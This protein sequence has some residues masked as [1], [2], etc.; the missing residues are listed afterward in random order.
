MSLDWSII[1]NIVLGLGIIIQG[2]GKIISDTKIKE[3]K[4][5]IIKTKEAQIT[6]FKELLVAEKEKNDVVVT[7]M[8]KK[9][10]ENLKIILTEKEEEISAINKSLVEKTMELENARVNAVNPVILEAELLKIRLDK[11]QLENDKLMLL[12]FINEVPL[13]NAQGNFPVENL[14]NGNL[15]DFSYESYLKSIRSRLEGENGDL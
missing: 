11:E 13:L 10:A 2:I 12:S 9:R 6:Y 1:I 4:D 15:L 8:F 14:L 7:E 5:E 3:A